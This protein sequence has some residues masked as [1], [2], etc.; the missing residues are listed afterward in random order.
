MSDRI[1]GSTT[2]TRPE[3]LAI[4]SAACGVAGPDNDVRS[5]DVVA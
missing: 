2:K 1:P 5:K 3:G 4:A